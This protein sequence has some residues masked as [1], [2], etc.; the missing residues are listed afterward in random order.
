MQ[1]T[2]GS[3]DPWVIRNSN[4][5]E[6]YVKLVLVTDTLIKIYLTIT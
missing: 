6:A 3:V 4:S 2:Y 1:Q 5:D